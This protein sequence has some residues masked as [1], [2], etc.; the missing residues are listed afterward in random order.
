[1]EKLAI[2][3]GKP[4]R[5]SLLPYGHQSVSEDD[6]RAVAEALRADWITQGAKVDEFEKRVADYCG[7]E[8]AVAVS[9]GTAALQLAYAAAGITAGDEVITTPITFAATASAAVHLG[10][11]PVFADIKE[12]TLNIDPLEIKKK[13]S[14]KTKAILPVDFAGLPAELDEIKQ[15]AAEKNLMVIEDACHALGAE[16][17][18][19]RIGGI[20]DMTVLSF[21]P[22]KHITTGEGGMVLTNRK[23]YYT[24]LKRLRHHGI[25][26]KSAEGGWYY[27]IESPG[28][29]FRLTDFQCALGLSQMD[30]LDGFI[31]RRRQI[32][33][34]YNK[35]FAEMEEIITPPHDGG[36]AYHIYV[37]QLRL[38]MLAADRKKIF[39]ALRAENI[40]V[41]VHYV[42]LHLHPFCKNSFGYRQGDYPVSER[43][44]S[45]AITLPLFPAMSDEDTRDVINGVRKVIVRFERHN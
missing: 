11:K 14:L 31:R 19:R 37:I 17:K 12:D 9:S 3:G 7:A 38:E 18:G 28:Y 26:K 4:V 5:G 1:M 40:G 33:A 25:E 45:R 22:V 6:I 10:A 23:E 35:A 41:Q 36:H 2:E 43:Y 29:N 24:K 42:P 44:Y 32:A 15:I 20:S 8:Y 27:Q 13:L 30:R 16:Y 34:A 21:H 39:E